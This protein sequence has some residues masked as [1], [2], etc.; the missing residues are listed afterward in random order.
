VPMSGTGTAVDPF[1]AE[2]IS[3]VIGGGAA[4]G[5][6]YVIRPT[7]PGAAGLE[8]AITSTRDIAAAAPV[9][10]EVSAANTGTGAISAGVVTD[11]DNAAFQ[12]TPG[13]LTPPVL[14]RFTSAA[15]YDVLD[16]GTMG[17]IDSGTYDPAQGEDIF[18][19]ENLAVDY[20][21]RV[22]ITG[23]PAAGD[24]FTVD[25][26]TGGVGDNRNALLLGSL[27]NEMTL[28]GGTT[29]FTGAYGQLVADVGI[30]TK[31]GEISSVA[32]GRLL[33]QAEGAREAVSGVNLDEEA[34][35]MVR[36]QQAYQAA[37]QVIAAADQVFQTL[38][39]A[40]R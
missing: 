25:F 31:Q 24:E 32:Q 30:K 22:R 18:P 14:I 36:F 28:N 5:D 39:D 34:A 35:N 33:Q 15:T 11:I 12:A 6:N 3:I 19:T 13:Q 4:A 7:R 10:T 38:I 23:N 17:V 2:G 26:N 8:V 40:V 21:Y 20:G 29:T 27:Q 1:V 9:R 16:A 37:A